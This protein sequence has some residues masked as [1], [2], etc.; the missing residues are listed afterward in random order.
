MSTTVVVI[1]LEV[2]LMVEEGMKEARCKGRRSE[3]EVEIEEEIVRDPL[4]I[5]QSI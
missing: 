3:V 2:T 5:R 4:K 1:S